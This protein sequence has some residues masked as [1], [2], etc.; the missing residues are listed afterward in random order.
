MMPMERMFISEVK[1][2]C[3]P[4]CPERSWNCH[5]WCE[6]YKAYRVECD[7]A[8]NDRYW[9]KQYK[10]EADEAAMKAVKRLPGKRNL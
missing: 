3:K 6:K 4:G 9:Q 7:K 10:R 2:V 5:T 8:M 1:T